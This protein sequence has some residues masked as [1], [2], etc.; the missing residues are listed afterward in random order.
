M[1]VRW[2][3]SAV[4][5]GFWSQP[6]DERPAAPA[7]AGQGTVEVRVWPFGILAAGDI[8]RPIALAL[9]EGFSLRSVVTALRERFGAQFLDG[10]VDA[11]DELSSHCRVFV[12]GRPVEDLSMP[13]ATGP[14][15]NIEIILLVAAEGG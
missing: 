5:G 11:Q 2:D 14:Q 12:D 7:G 13:V 8:Q 10:V 6:A 1:K 9:R 3:A 15:S 4:A